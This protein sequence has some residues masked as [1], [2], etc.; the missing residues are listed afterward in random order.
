MV[1]LLQSCVICLILFLGP[2][3][4]KWTTK[5]L[6]RHQMVS[7][8]HD[9]IVIGGHSSRI[10]DGYGYSNNLFKLSCNNNAC[11]WETLSQKMKIPR[12]WF[13]AISVPDDFIT[14]SNCKSEY[15][16]SP[17]C[18]IKAQAIQSSQLSR[19]TQSK[20]TDITTTTAP[21]QVNCF[22]IFSF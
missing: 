18:R 16:D 22:I 3:L 2:D 4:P 6:S 11:N 9:L 13:V 20:E 17:N 12:V 10:D 15:N 8:G 5:T 14:C 7:I 21:S 1:K 19:L